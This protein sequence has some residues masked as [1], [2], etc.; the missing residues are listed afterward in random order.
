MPDATQLLRR[1]CWLVLSLLALCGCEGFPKIEWPDW[2]KLK[3]EKEAPPTARL[4]EPNDPIHTGTIGELT[5]LG[6][7]SAEPV[8][9][10][11]IVVGLGDKG[12]S[13]CPTALREY[14]LERMTK[15]VGPRSQRR[16]PS[17]SELLDS[18]DSAV[19]EIRGARPPGAPKG[20]PFDVQVVVVPGTSTQS[21]SGGVLLPTP[22]SFYDPDASGTGMFEGEPLAAAR[23]PIFTN[24]FGDG[25]DASSADLRRG[26]ILGG[27]RVLEQRIVRLTLRQPRYDLAID[28]QRRLKERFGQRPPTA[29]AESAGYLTLH[30]PSE[31]VTE[32]AHFLDLVPYVLL[33]RRP[34]ENEAR[35]RS[36][37]QV[38]LEGSDQLQDIS[39]ALES[40]GRA[41]VP[42]VQPVYTHDDP[43]VRFYAARA[44]LRGGD[45]SAIPVLGE[46]AA[47]APHG[48][49]LL[50]IEE[51]GRCESPQAPLKIAPLLDDPEREVR[52]AAY[53]ALL[54][55]THPAIH[56]QSIPLA[57]DRSQLNFALDVI[58][59]RGSPLIYVRRTRMPRI[60]VFGPRTALVPPVFYVA[61]DDTLTIHTIGDETNVRIF[62]RRNGRLTDEIVV[63]PRVPALIT[64][65]ADVPARDEAGQLRGLGLPYA[66]VVQVVSQLCDQGVIKAGFVLEQTSLSELLGPETTPRR[67]EGDQGSATEPAAEP[68][69]AEAPPEPK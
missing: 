57:M 34:D 18:L 5:L 69:P 9:G 32:P 2:G 7:V 52:I 40:A 8:R 66:R 50:A 29:E 60:A 38:A 37:V 45:V 63:P 54:K 55:H 4:N 1:S 53:E 24:P 59:S 51:L 6:N 19:V 16:G 56:S 31:Y 28:I 48:V 10:F 3:Q 36:L 21:L 47:N 58:D 49:R 33:S 22:L 17:P 39:L 35:L 68:P 46:L 41:C 23:G 42:H 27:A 26:V 44:G 13:D 30:T 67:A 15:Q 11:G 61:E 25:A 62:M 12:S 14:L 43:T 64:A 65:L 20:T